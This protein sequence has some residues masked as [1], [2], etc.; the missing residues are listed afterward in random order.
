MR[1]LYADRLVVISAE[2]PPGRAGAVRVEPAVA[3]VR[4]AKP[5]AILRIMMS[6]V[7]DLSA[8][9]LRIKPHNS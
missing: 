7:F 1:R 2:P 6:I 5:L 4:A 9:P 8:Q 3:I